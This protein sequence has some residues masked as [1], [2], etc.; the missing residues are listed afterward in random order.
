MK[1]MNNYVLNR[2]SL[3][4]FIDCI[5][6]SADSENL[7]LNSLIEECS[8]YTSSVHSNNYFLSKNIQKKINKDIYTNDYLENTYKIQAEKSFFL[9]ELDGKF[10][11][12]LISHTSNLELDLDTHL[13]EVQ[14]DFI[15]SNYGKQVRY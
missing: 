11:T 10:I 6:N 7:E 1:I 2:E 5:L 4:T 15:N 14:E 8:Y 12:F 9:E 3:E 13:K